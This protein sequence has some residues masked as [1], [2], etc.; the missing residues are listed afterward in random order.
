MKLPPMPIK[1]VDAIEK[2]SDLWTGER[3]R[4][5]PD[6]TQFA[7]AKLGMCEI[8][9]TL[10]S[11]YLK[12]EDSKHELVDGYTV[13]LFEMGEKPEDIAPTLEELGAKYKIWTVKELNDLPI[14]T[15]FDH[16]ILGGCVIEHV[17]SKIT[18][19][20]IGKAMKFD[21]EFLSSAVFNNDAYPWT[22]PMKIIFDNKN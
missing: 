9:S 16:S 17:F 22:V 8:A 20:K 7:H 21:N 1:L 5:L 6:G 4:K 12:F 14:G 15:R 19:E 10:T 2:C 3:L 11:K 18:N 13:K